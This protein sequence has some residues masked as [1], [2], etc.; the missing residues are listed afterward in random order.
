MSYFTDSLAKRPPRQTSV[1]SNYKSQSVHEKLLDRS[2][3]TRSDLSSLSTKKQYVAKNAKANIIKQLEQSNMDLE[4]IIDQVEQELEIYYQERRNFVRS[5]GDTYTGSL[6]DDRLIKDVRLK[7]TSKRIKD[8]KNQ[9]ELL[10]KKKK[11]L[12]SKVLVMPKSEEI[13]AVTDKIKMV[14]GEID[15]IKKEIAMK[16]KAIKFMKQGSSELPINDSVVVQK[17]QDIKQQIQQLRKQYTGLKQQFTSQTALNKQVARSVV[18]ETIRKRQLSKQAKETS[19]ARGSV[20]YRSVSVDGNS[21]E[22]V[23]TL[24]DSDNEYGMGGFERPLQSSMSQSDNK[25]R[26]EPKINSQIRPS[27]VAFKSPA[28]K[29]PRATI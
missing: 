9:K 21:Q 25:P 12:Q 19:K 23:V 20:Q 2:I 8:A 18:D 26:P 29:P 17:N 28:E 3:E 1:Q 13:R 14:A 5:E 27:N 11:K 10:E 16:Q 22:R 4:Y 15:A 7:E 24:A 6:L